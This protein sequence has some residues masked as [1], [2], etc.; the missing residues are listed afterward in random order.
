MT[1]RILLLAGIFALA[2]IL[3]FP[4]AAQSDWSVYLFDSSSQQVMRVGLDGKAQPYDLGVPSGAV[5][6]QGAIDFAPDGKR[7]VYCTPAGADGHFELIVKNLANTSGQ[8]L[9][10]NVGRGQ[11][12]WVKFSDDASQIAVGLV[13]YYAGDSSADTSVPP[14]S[15]LVI[16]AATG[17]QLHEMDLSKGGSNFDAK[18]TIMP[19]VRYFANG[20]II[21]AGLA[22]GTDG[23][24]SSPA[25]LW[26]LSDDS[27]LLIDR[28]WHSG[29]DSLSSTG[30]L[31]WTE[32][33]PSRPA[34]QPDGPIPQAN[35]VKLANMG[36]QERVIYTT[37][38]WV[39]LSATFIDN[40][41]QIAINQVQ[42]A[43]QNRWI[44][45]DRS[46][47]SSQLATTSGFSQIMAAP[48]GYVILWSSDNS[49]SAVLTL[50]YYSGREKTTLWQQQASGGINWSLLWAAPTATADNL[51]PFPAVN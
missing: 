43:D 40:G 44:A 10:V 45:L 1:R 4:A 27:I 15:L 32:L 41:R 5:L 35:I 28:W 2:L 20:Q 29:L 3:T 47:A 18:Q 30:E 21:F 31:V 36:G 22:W 38:D 39:V 14:W 19:E 33:D 23:S 50:D 46:G 37:P 49:A 12:C 6:G 7:I 13:R 24:P 48:D 8:P 26:T 9:Q 25:Y 51:Q 34:A 17:N 42:G 11:G 16:D